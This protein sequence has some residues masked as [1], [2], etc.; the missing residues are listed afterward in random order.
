M[1]T[2][3]TCKGCSKKID[4]KTLPLK[5]RAYTPVNA[6]A[7]S[8]AEIECSHKGCEHRESVLIPAGTLFS[9]VPKMLE[10]ALVNAPVSPSFTLVVNVA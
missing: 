9:D 4:P 3:Y 10:R 1:K 7:F 5:M 6:C 2:K 8:V